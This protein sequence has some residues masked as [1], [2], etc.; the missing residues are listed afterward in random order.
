MANILLLDDDEVAT[1]ALQGVLSHG[2]HRTVC[3]GTVDEALRLLAE[4]V[5]IDLVF[6]EV[7]LP[8]R[9]GLEFLQKVKA[10]PF[11]KLL[12]CVVYTG[13]ANSEVVKKC[14]TLGVQNYLIKPYNEEA[15]HKEVA[16]AVS[17]PWRNLHFEEAKSY[18]RLMGITLEDLVKE[19]DGLAE[20][21]AAQAPMIAGRASAHDPGVGLFFKE[22]AEA[23]ET[24]GAWGV[25]EFA[26][27]RNR[28]A[29]FGLW[30]QLAQ[31]HEELLFASRLLH[32]Q[33]HPEPLVTPAEAAATEA[34]KEEE[35]LRS[36]WMNA[37]LSEGRTFIDRASVELQVQELPAFPVMENVGA[38]FHMAADSKS[39]SLTHLIDLV[40]KDPSLTAQVLIAA[41]ALAHDEGTTIEDTRIA[42]G[43]LGNLRLAALAR[44]MPTLPERLMDLP[45]ISW[46]HFWAFQM[47]VARMTQHCCVALEFPNLTSIAFTA[48]LLHDVGKLIL[49]KLFP[50]GFPAMVQLSR[51]ENISLQAA[52]V[53]YLG[54]DAQ[55]LGGWFA[56]SH[57]L[58]AAYHSVIRYVNTPGEAP[59]EHRE[60]V[61]MVSLARV[62]CLHSHVGFC[63]D[64]AK[65]TSPP[66]EE[67]AAWA[68]L[69]ERVFPAFNLKEFEH[70]AH[71]VCL[72]L[73]QE[74]AGRG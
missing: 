7:K 56:A 57:G 3:A 71:G 12:P 22:I 29:S 54:C 55:E 40:N 45:P 59:A 30:D 9:N 16:R 51:R 8:G 37:D 11:L 50:H 38:A 17:N 24:A 35:R 4:I 69:R 47:G 6:L 28:A 23:A 72:K 31:T 66:L 60:L 19:R 36:L 21:L 68:V 42:V 73:K 34:A 46:P 62:L 43:K 49:L 70:Q 39:A 61:A 58:P 14:L 74:L 64:T 52:E 20:R 41:N 32:Y 27:A 26:Q 67:S 15:V 25:V 48:G 53:R 13:I 44:S 18:C 1:R 5:R 65:D 2:N 63:G 10:D 33:H